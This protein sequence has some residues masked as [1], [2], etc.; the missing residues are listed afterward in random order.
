VSAYI[1]DA[2]DVV[3]LDFSPTVGREQSGHRPAAVLTPRAYNERSGLLFCVPLTT[4]VK[5]YTFEVSVGSGADAGV[6]LVDQSRSIDW[7]RRSVRRKGKLTEDELSRVRLR[8][9]SLIGEP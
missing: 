6:A 7:Q 5:G 2:G 9:R 3:W 8:L 1:P 4:R